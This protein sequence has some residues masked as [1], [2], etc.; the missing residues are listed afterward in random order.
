MRKCRSAG[1]RSRH[2][3]LAAAGIG[4]GSFLPLLAPGR[5]H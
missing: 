1:H 3:V 4:S 5:L 2:A